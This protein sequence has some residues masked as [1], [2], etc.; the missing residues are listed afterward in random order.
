M[1]AEDVSVSRRTGLLDDFWVIGTKF[2]ST[3]F[4]SVVVSVD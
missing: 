2:S 1:G 4:E 3:V